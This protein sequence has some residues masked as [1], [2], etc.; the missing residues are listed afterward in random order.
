MKVTDPNLS[1]PIST[2]PSASLGAAGVQ[3][4]SRTSIGSGAG[5]PGAGDA[6]S[7][8]GVHLSE[9]VRSLRSLAADSDLGSA[10]SAILGCVMLESR[11]NA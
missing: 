5:V 4:S 2:G 3:S 1:S 10:P 9:L 11:W 7:S 8:D 6:A